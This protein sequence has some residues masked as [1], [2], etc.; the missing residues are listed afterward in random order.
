MRDSQTF[1][2][3]NSANNYRVSDAVSSLKDTK[4]PERGKLIILELIYPGNGSDSS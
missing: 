3:A 4:Q 1:A 2:S